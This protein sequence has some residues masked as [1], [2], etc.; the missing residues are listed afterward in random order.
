MRSSRVAKW[1]ERVAFPTSAA[2]ATEAI[3][4]PSTSVANCCRVVGVVLVD[5][6]IRIEWAPV[7]E[8]ERILLLED[9]RSRRRTPYDR[10]NWSP[11]SERR[12]PVLRVARPA[13]SVADDELTSH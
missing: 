4:T 5:D 9:G 11:G 7:V 12:G 1:R 13:G 6:V 8:S 3:E 2:R 10:P